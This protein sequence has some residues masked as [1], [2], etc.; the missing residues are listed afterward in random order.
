MTN[1]R[2]HRRPRTIHVRQTHTRTMRMRKLKRN[3]IMTSKPH[4]VR[5]CEVVLSLLVGRPR[6]GVSCFPADEY[7]APV[8]DSKTSASRNSEFSQ[9]YYDGSSIPHKQQ[10]APTQTNFDKTMPPPL[11]P[12]SK[13]SPIKISTHSR[14][15]EK[16]VQAQSSRKR[17]HASDDD[18]ERQIQ[19]IN[20]KHDGR[21]DEQRFVGDDGP[22]MS[23]ALPVESA[24]ETGPRL[25]P[26]R[27]T[28]VR[29]SGSSK[30]RNV[31]YPQSS[32][33]PDEGHHM[34]AQPNMVLPQAT[35][36]RVPLSSYSWSRT[37]QAHQSNQINAT[38]SSSHQGFDGPTRQYSASPTKRNIIMQNPS[39]S[40]PFFR[41]G[42][43]VNRPGTLGRPVAQ[44]IL[45]Q[46]SFQDHEIDRQPFHRQRPQLQ[47][48]QAQSST[49]R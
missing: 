38:P 18:F 30:A 16:H 45:Q 41:P 5:L 35:P 24:S 1:K 2:T 20:S 11:V 34:R 48:R 8:N 15:H 27:R 42:S 6:S 13:S 39:V 29:I 3:S 40:S 33:P 43:S 32:R 44:P 10:H 9:Y 49:L 36:Q 19:M 37:A 26:Q 31:Q 14:D 22:Y 4:Q 21:I 17:S 46:Q 47:S 7:V 12:A 23:G 28:P 25:E